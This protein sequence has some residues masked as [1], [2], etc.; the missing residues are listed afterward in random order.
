MCLFSFIFQLDFCFG[1]AS[2]FQ[3]TCIIYVK[4]NLFENGN[5]YDTY[6][7]LVLETD[8]IADDPSFLSLR[9][10]DLFNLKNKIIQ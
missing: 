2:S 1:L 8:L 7:E 4:Y 10:V 3:S 5:I 6:E 9:I